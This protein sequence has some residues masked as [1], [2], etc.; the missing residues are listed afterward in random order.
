MLCRSC[1]RNCLKNIIIQKKKKK[2]WKRASRL[3]SGRAQKAPL[4]HVH[5]QRQTAAR[6]QEAMAEHSFSLAV[7]TT[8]GKLSFP[9]NGA[10]TATLSVRVKRGDWKCAFQPGPHVTGRTVTG[11]VHVSVATRRTGCFYGLL[12]SQ[13]PVWPM[14]ERILNTASGWSHVQLVFI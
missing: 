4:R 11:S 6:K 1:K 8:I 5:L 10:K 9:E 13:R 7:E 14:L 12:K 3:Q 2:S